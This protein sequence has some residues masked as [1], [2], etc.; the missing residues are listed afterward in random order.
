MREKT[1]SESLKAGT[2]PMIGSIVVLTL[3]GPFGTYEDFAFGP[4]LVFWTLGILSGSLFIHVAVYYLIGLTKGTARD[5][6]AS[7]VAGA[8]VGSVPASV[9]IIYIYASMVGLAVSRDF[10]L[11]IWGNVAVIGVLVALAHVIPEV[12]RDHIRQA[13]AE[14]ERVPEPVEAVAE[15]LEHVPLIE[16]LPNGTRPCQIMSFSMQDHYVEIATMDGTSLHLMTFGA[17]M[18]KLG[19]LQGARVHRSHWVSKRHLTDIR[20]DGRR[21][22]AV[23]TDNRAIPISGPYLDSAR[24]LLAEKNATG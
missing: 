14:A 20:K 1:L 23:L 22:I 5:K 2:L 13:K 3:T 4:R 6:I 9:A 21:H 8:I 11:P 10:F 18:D 15:Q 17:A 16:M 12:I 7:A 19:D 24:A